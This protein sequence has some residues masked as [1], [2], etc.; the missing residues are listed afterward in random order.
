M[1]EHVARCGIC[2]HLCGQGKEMREH[3]DWHRRRDEV[4]R[5]NSAAPNLLEA[6]KSALATMAWAEKAVPGTNFQADILKLRAAIA[7]AEGETVDGDT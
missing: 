4:E 5:L 7:K 3:H 1:A 6:C 2:G